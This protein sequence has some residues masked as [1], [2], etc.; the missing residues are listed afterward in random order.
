MSRLARRWWNSSQLKAAAKELARHA[1]LDI[2]AYQ[3]RSS[4]D[5]RRAR[6]LSDL[7]VQLVLDVGANVGQYGERLR[8]S[9]YSRRIVSFEPLPEPWNELRRRAQQDGNWEA[10]NIA[11]G[12]RSGAQTMHIAAG[13]ASSSLLDAAQHCFD[14]P[15]ATRFVAD[16]HVRVARLDELASSLMHDGQSTYIKLDVQGYELAVL[17]GAI[18]TLPHIAAIEAE[19][20]LVELYAGQPQYRE[21]IDYLE[22]R[23][24]DA[25]SFEPAFSDQAT[26]RLLQ[27]DGIFFRAQR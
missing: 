8:A 22:E 1:G 26:G 4:P 2:R 17:G 9:G 5:A 3:P 21:V 14:V 10:I 16:T 25:F 20:S 18:A 11:L 27:M 15:E 7:G 13:S 24:F 6:L 19:L 23:G 12:D